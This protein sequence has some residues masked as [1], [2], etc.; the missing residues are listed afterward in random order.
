MNGSF[1]GDITSTVE[2]S[3]ITYQCDDGLTPEGTMT[4]VCGEDREWR[5]KPGDVECRNTTEDSKSLYTTWDPNP[6]LQMCRETNTL[7]RYMHIIDEVMKSRMVNNQST[8][9]LLMHYKPFSRSV[10]SER[11]VTGCCGGRFPKS[12]V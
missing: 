12:D 9:V 3:D 6:A 2:S 1:R 11:L 4:A 8:P 10:K 5:P 7:G